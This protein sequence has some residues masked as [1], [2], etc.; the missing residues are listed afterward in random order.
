[1]EFNSTN[2]NTTFTDIIKEDDDGLPEE[3]RL[4]IT[5]VLIIIAILAIL[6]Y[7]CCLSAQGRC[8]V[9]LFCFA[10]SEVLPK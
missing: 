4:E 9:C 10:S 8:C 1:M 7:I 2:N 3:V 5:I 6:I